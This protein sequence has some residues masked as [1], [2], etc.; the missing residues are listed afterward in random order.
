VILPRWQGRIGRESFT[1]RRPCSFASPWLPPPLPPP[2]QRRRLLSHG[3]GLRRWGRVVRFGGRRVVRL[4]IPATIA[5]AAA[6]VLATAS[7]A[8]ASS[9]GDR[10]IADWRDG[11]IDGTYSPR[12]LRNALRSLP[13][14]LR[15]YGSAEA[16]ISL[17]LSRALEPPRS[18]SSHRTSTP[19]GT[20]RR[21][22]AS[23]PVATE[24]A[25]F[26]ARAAIVAGL[27]GIA[28]VTLVASLW[29]TTRRRT[30]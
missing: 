26:S 10:V 21:A 28:A 3:G 18:L 24:E 8:S 11:R 15:I 27:V 30:R 20:V 17:A 7:P 9:C 19:Q 22:A 6:A 13:E 16:D 29:R 23:E 12:C 5:I 14:D 25:A 1:A 4:L 2:A